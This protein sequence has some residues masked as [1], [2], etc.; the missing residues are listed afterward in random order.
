MV[1]QSF[2]CSLVLPLTLLDL[3]EDWEL[4]LGSSKGR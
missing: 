4:V 3:F 1:L 2:D